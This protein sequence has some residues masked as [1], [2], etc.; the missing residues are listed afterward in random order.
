[1]LEDGQGG[2]L[3]IGGRL[4]SFDRLDTIYRL[5]DGDSKWQ[6]LDQRL[7]TYREY[8]VVM[9]VPESLTDCS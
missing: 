2:I 1:M 7:K 5:R 9:T 3:F 8:P 6:L 4:D